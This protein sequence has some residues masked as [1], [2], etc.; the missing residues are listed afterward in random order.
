[1]K[2]SCLF[3][4]TLVI[5][6]FSLLAEAKGIIRGVVIDGESGETLI[7]AA[8]VIKESQQGTS[9]DLDG[10]Y[11]F[12]LEPGTYTIVA[13]FISFQTTTI[14]DVTV[15]DNEVTVI[16]I[17]LRESSV[18]L[19]EVTVAA[20]I[21]RNTEN[22]VLL[23]QKKAASVVDGISSQQIKR[24]GDSDAAGAIKRVPGV[25]V[26]GGRYV[27]VR[28]LGDR[29]SKILL[30][31][32]EIPSLDP[33]RN[34]VQLDLFPTN[35]IDNMIVH[36]T[37]TPDLPGSFTGGLINLS[38]KDFPEKK[39]I[40][41]SAS[42]GY[43]SNA[44]FN[45]DFITHEGGSTDWLGFDN[46]DRDIPS[47][48]S[49]GIPEVF[50]GQDAEIEAIT[51][52]FNKNWVTKKES[53]FMNQS[54]ALSIG[55]QKK[56]FGERSFGYIASLSYSAKNRFYDDGVV[57]RYNVVSA[58]SSNELNPLYT[59]KDQQSTEEVLWGAVLN[60]HLKLN[61]NHSIGFNFMRNQ[62]GTQTTRILSGQSSEIQQYSPDYIFQSQ[63]L[64]YRERSITTAQLKG[65]HNLEKYNNT[66]IE[67][68]SSYTSSEQN[69]P[70]LRFF[71]SDYQ[72]MR[73]DNGNITDTLFSIDQSS[74]DIPTRFFRDMK[75]NNFDN[76]V[77][78]T[79]PYTA[80]TIKKATLKVGGGFLWKDRDFN[81]RQFDFLQ[82]PFNGDIEDFFANDNISVLNG[83]YA[84]EATDPRNSYEGTQTVTAAYAMTDL[85]LR[86]ELRLI[87]GARY[88]YTN[89]EVAS[90]NPALD[91]GELLDHD[92]L[93]SINLSY[94]LMKDM[95]LRGSYSRTLARPT[96]RELSPFPSFSFTGDFIL[97]GNPDLERT[98]IDNMDVRWEWYPKPGEYLSISGFYKIFDGPIEKT[99]DPR[100]A[101]LQLSYVNVGD[102]NVLGME[103]EVRKRL[104][105]ITSSL[106]QFR[107]GVNA[108]FI[109]SRVSIDPAEL[110]ARQAIDPGVSDKRPMYGQSPY[111]LNS[112]LM[113]DN[114]PLGISAAISVNTFGERLAIVSNGALPDVYEQSRTSLDL[115]ISKAIGKYIT[116]G[117]KA[118]NLLDPE[119]KFTHDYKG[120]EYLF[121]NSSRGRT[122]TLSFRYSLL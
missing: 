32:A 97:V 30:N 21:M 121:S 94:T 88:E 62:S 76:S 20:K 7:G 111:I 82:A 49:N 77:H 38:T 114:D 4:L 105:F 64:Q 41:F 1:M 63:T 31:G 95:N 73:D 19:E 71:A 13:S 60:T 68:I 66:R 107:V 14:T 86:P 52:E 84:D 117:L 99:V 53:P 5:F 51:R 26:E 61:N 58:G 46:G 93:P 12:S 42:G 39:T 81:E 113:Y 29:Y 80:G 54:Y 25:S 33:E 17:T 92:I 122:F 101:N 6:G 67:W 116:L 23:K 74:Y 102:A 90:K 48:A 3:I 87:I 79:I 91:K 59:L 72:L 35:L 57:G 118:Q 98:L 11:E 15:K 89:M 120:Q 108:S 18:Q 50:Q 28:G 103:I 85:Q 106:R 112:Y 45:S 2:R 16:D 109:D 70:D 43:N 44:T 110:A 119:Y 8:V 115:S 78:V 55:D 9:T 40:H 69:Q 36:K 83:T 10:K 75:E 27:S 47:G 24:M 34:A 22:A 65:E 100:A 56:V 96:F 37:Y 104:D